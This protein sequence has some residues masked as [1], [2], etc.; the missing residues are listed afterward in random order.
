MHRVKLISHAKYI[1]MQ[2]RDVIF[3]ALN[4]TADFEFILLFICNCYCKGILSFVEG[5]LFDLNP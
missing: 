1:A 3:I 4:G 2:T 5:L